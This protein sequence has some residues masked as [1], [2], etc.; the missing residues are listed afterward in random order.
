MGFSEYM[1]FTQITVTSVKKD[2]DI[3]KQ[4]GNSM[5]MLLKRKKKRRNLEMKTNF[6]LQLQ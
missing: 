3:N 2:V 6:L 5:H 1:N 4:P